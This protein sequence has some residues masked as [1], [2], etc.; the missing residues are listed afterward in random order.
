MFSG[1]W[2]MTIR[3]TK[4]HKGYS[5]INI[6]GLAIGLACCILILLYVRYE[7]SYDT[8]HEHADRIFRVVEKLH[9]HGKDSH[10]AITQAPLAPAL[11][12]DFPEVIHAV[13]LMDLR[14]WG[15]QVLVANR[16]KCF[17]EDRWLF[18]DAPVFDVFTFPLIKGISSTAL[19]NP[20]SVVITENAAKK[21]FGDA[22]PMGQSL[23]INDMHNFTVT[24][25]LEDVPFNSHFRFD[26][27]ASFSTVEKWR[28]EWLNNWFNHNY[29]TYILLAKSCHPSD[30]ESR[31]PDFI[32]KYTGEQEEI[33]LTYSLQSLT[34]IHLHSNLESEIE[35]NSDIV[36]IY[37]FSSIAVFVLLIACINFINLS[38]A[39]AVSRAREVGMRKVLGARRSQLIKQ[40]LGESVLFVLLA[41]PI[42]FAMVQIVLPYY[43]AFTDKTMGFY[44]F[45]NGSDILLSILVVLFISMLS[46]LYPALCLSGFKSIGVLKGIESSRR[47]SW[48][49]KGLI[50]FQFI[51]SITLIASTI[52]IKKQTHYIRTKKLGF[53][54]EQIVVLP[55][56]RDQRLRDM[57]EI[58]K[59]ELLTYRNILNVSASSGMPGRV[60]HH[61]IFDAEGEEETGKRYSAWIM[62]VDHDFIETLGIEIIEGRDF[63]EHLATDEKEAILLNESAKATFDWDSPLGKN[64]KTENK[65]GC[66]V[67]VVKDFHFKSLYQ[68]IEPLLIYIYPRY[69]YIAI[70]LAPDDIPGS[71]AFI[72]SRW[73]ALAP[74]R[75][76]EYY[77]LD[78]D[79]NR[80]YRAEER[81]GDMFECFA[82]LSIVVACLG[83]YGLISYSVER[84]KREIVIRK[85]L[86]ASVPN[87]SIL[88][89]RQFLSLVFAASM[90]AWPVAYFTIKKW[91][92]NFAYRTNMDF[93]SFLISTV[94][95]L[96]VALIPVSYQSLKAALADPART[97]RVE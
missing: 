73:A 20:F 42:A 4:R 23:F 61:W 77:F 14:G 49:R 29:Y 35:S 34:D 72:K 81:L 11:K 86:G 83:L 38:T 78:N 22:D 67:G 50:V 41:L 12:T 88:L 69:Q 91:L 53:N 74:D 48:L 62:M 43:N 27:L 92:Q 18:A 15:D 82:F 46:G 57:Y 93:G 1:P 56:M 5:L 79:F 21:Y 6:A 76:F 10:M 24:G 51:I 90:V 13:R 3:F 58:I 44:L 52:I 84:R 66:V 28:G 8:Y 54:K 97:L 75:P 85:V 40:F 32:R 89:S 31:L 33:R 25:V 7:L 16:E 17:Y 95:A 37:I 65:E 19:R 59:S 94:L 96:I 30:L 9:W 80:R 47:G 2:K 45:N 39:T 36:I 60:T 55:I 63:S 64:I 71:M 68:S 87:I 70:R 26:F